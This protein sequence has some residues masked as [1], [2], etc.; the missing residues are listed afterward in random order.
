[1]NMDTGDVHPIKVVAR[2]TGLT[3]HVLRMWEKRYGAV[4]PLRTPTNRRLY[5]D[6]D[7][8]R[9]VLLRKATLAGRNIGQIAH[10]PTNKLQALLD[11]DEETSQPQSSMVGAKADASVSSHLNACLHAVE[12]LDAAALEAALLR[13]ATVL[14]RITLIEHV[15]VPLIHQI[16]ERWREGSLRVVHEHIASVTV[17][18]ALE[19][20]RNIS[21]VPAAAPRLV[22]TT[23]A[24]QLH[25]LG[26]LLVAATATTEGWRA[27]YLGANLPAEEIA[28]ATEKLQAQAAALSIVYPPDDPHL[29]SELY[30]LRRSLP[31][32][33]VLIV[34]GR[35]AAHY[36]AV[37][38]PIGAIKLHDIPSLRATLETL[39][40][41]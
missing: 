41:R 4:T 24:G 34:G 7:I 22:V 38:D 39:R 26:A 28:A 3:P 10:L 36:Q 40:A 23:P 12:Q 31:T 37:L 15:I 16:G 20:M 14:G 5:S 30:N 8:V 21:T 35:A 17:R 18:I 27:T 32:D 6:A 11:A 2:R 13:A 25:E 29:G 9:L 1:M 19:G 33:V